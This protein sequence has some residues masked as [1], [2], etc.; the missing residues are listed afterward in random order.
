MM[1]ALDRLHYMKYVAGGNS[2]T[3]EHAVYVG[4]T[5]LNTRPFWHRHCSQKFS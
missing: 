5:D 2:F 3:A 4:I 1:V